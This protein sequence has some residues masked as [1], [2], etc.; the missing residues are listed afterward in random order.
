MECYKLEE[1]MLKEELVTAKSILVVGLRNEVPRMIESLRTNGEQHFVSMGVETR[2][3][4][5]HFEAAVF[6]GNSP[7]F[8]GEALFDALFPY[9]Q[10]NVDKFYILK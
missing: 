6:Q 4:A 2:M 3:V 5:G 8:T 9:L 1:T 10:Y 7:L